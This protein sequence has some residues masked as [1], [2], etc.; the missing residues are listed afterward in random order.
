MFKLFLF[1]LTSF[2]TNT[3]LNL[4][5]QIILVLLGCSW[6]LCFMLS[7]FVS[8]YTY[9]K[10]LW[11]IPCHLGLIVLA[12]WSQINKNAYNFEFLCLGISAFLCAFIFAI[13]NKDNQIKSEHINLA[14]I[15]NEQAKNLENELDEDSLA[16]ER[17]QIE[18]IKARPK[19]QPEIKSNQEL[20]YSHVKKVLNKLE[21]YSITSQERKQTKELMQAVELAESQGQTAELKEKINEGLGA[22][23][24]IMSKY[25][26]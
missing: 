20:D 6:A 4:Y 13:P 2:L 17:T 15:F 16:Q 25:A 3:N 19:E 21:Y 9:K 26:V 10:R 12:W 11:I 1:N 23:L 24:K 22:L 7:L 5:L 18:V 14:R 8:E